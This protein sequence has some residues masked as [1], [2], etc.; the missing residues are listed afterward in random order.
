LLFSQPSVHDLPERFSVHVVKLVS[1]LALER[2]QAS[3]LQ[4]P[5]VLGDPLPAERE[6]VLHG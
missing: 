4:N 5:K 2:D 6:L 3:R 1:A